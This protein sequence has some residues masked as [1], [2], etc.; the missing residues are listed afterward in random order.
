MSGEPSQVYVTLECNTYVP[1]T[2]SS[3][4]R[5]EPGL[6]DT[7]ETNS[8]RSTK[9][10]R[11]RVGA[12][13]VTEAANGV[14]VDDLLPVCSSGVRDADHAMEPRGPTAL[15]EERQRDIRERAVEG[16]AIQEDRW[17]S[18]QSWMCATPGNLG[19][20][21]SER[22]VAERGRADASFGRSFH[23]TYT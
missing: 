17:T 11:W 1:A 18:D 22:R 5:A 12:Q 23:K 20:S 16:A 10:E 21:V 6:C 15:S 4:R 13:T 19:T 14:D 8:S 2:S 7:G 9:T 3:E